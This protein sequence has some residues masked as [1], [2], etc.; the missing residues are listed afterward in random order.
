[1]NPLRIFVIPALIHLDSVPWEKV[2]Y[3]LIRIGMQRITCLVKYLRDRVLFD[4]EKNES[5][6]RTTDAYENNQKYWE[7]VRRDTL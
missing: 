1:M 2:M 3:P 7:K 5:I 6:S 4:T